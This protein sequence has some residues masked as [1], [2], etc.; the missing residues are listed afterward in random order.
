MSGDVCLAVHRDGRVELLIQKCPCGA[1]VAALEFPA[2]GITFV[3]VIG[4]GEAVAIHRLD[5]TKIEDQRAFGEVQP[6]GVEVVVHCLERSLAVGDWLAAGIRRCGPGDGA[7]VHHDFEFGKL[8][9]VGTGVVAQL[10]GRESEVAVKCR[11]GQTHGGGGGAG[12]AG[13]GGGERVGYSADWGD[14]QTSRGSHGSD[15]IGNGDGVRI[16][17]LPCEHR[18]AACGND[19]W[20]AG[21]CND[22]GRRRSS[23]VECVSQDWPFLRIR[24]VRRGNPEAPL[25]GGR[26]QR[27]GTQPHEYILSAF[28]AIGVGGIQPVAQSGIDHAIG[29]R[30]V[31]GIAR[32]GGGEKSR[33]DARAGAAVVR[34][35]THV[36]WQRGAGRP[37]RGCG[38]KIHLI[39]DIDVGGIERHRNVRKRTRSE[40]GKLEG[41]Y[42]VVCH[43]RIVLAADIQIGSGNR[44]WS[45]RHRT[46]AAGVEFRV[47]AMAVDDIRGGHAGN[48]AGKQEN[49]SAEAGSGAWFHGRNEGG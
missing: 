33:H 12:S 8:H 39:G 21:E 7:A 28:G 30:R 37:G 13:A 26:V 6:L 40:V 19:S 38:V 2:H 45:A 18:G 42:V 49:D 3:G 34:G 29:W 17:H 46:A 47:I 25:M 20:C 23:C 43:I 48:D 36:R 14:F 15:A 16:V 27:I 1:V 32:G 22:R 4:R 44:I 11:A 5:L 10:C 41:H 31:G 24:M 35:T 9:A